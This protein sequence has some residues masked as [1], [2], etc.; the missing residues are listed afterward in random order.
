MDAKQIAE[1][2]IVERYL[3]NQLTDP[4]ADAFEAYVE[5]HP[6]IVREIELA[7][8]MKSGLATLRQR[9]DLETV[10]HAKRR[11][12]MRRPALLAASVAVVLI[13]G[14]FIVRQWSAAPQAVLLA[15]T[16]EELLGNGD[17]PLAIAAR[18]FVTRTRGEPAESLAAPPAAAVLEL[19][20][21]LHATDPSA[22]Y[23]V[24]LLRV[25]GSALNDVG[26]LSRASARADGSLSFFVRGSALTAGN[27]LI[28]V[29]GSDSSEPVEF[30]LR[31]I[32]AAP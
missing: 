1:R 16:A 21:D 10:T 23:S 20:L 27:Y 24:H 13:A 18:L 25:A 30:S 4:E 22:T 28:R 8:R 14:A 6:E 31:V 29:A 3:A 11:S 26:G 12:G 5:A 2:H 19:T 15:S 9:G 32:P 7:T 17:Q